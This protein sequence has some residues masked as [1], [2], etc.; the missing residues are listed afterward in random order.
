M[1]ISSWRIATLHVDLQTSEERKAS[2]RY[3]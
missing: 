1:E 3:G 2:Y